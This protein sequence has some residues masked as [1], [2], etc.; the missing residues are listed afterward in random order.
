MKSNECAELN[1]CEDFESS[2]FIYDP[3]DI[4]DSGI[5]YILSDRFENIAP[6]YDS[7]TGPFRLLSAIRYGKKY[8]LKCLKNDIGIP[9]IYEAAFLK[10]FEIG[11]SLDHPNIRSTIGIQEV[12]GIGKAIILEY[13]DGEN[14]EQFLS[15]G[16]I[17]RE[18]ARYIFMQVCF[19]L[20]YMHRKQIIHRDLKTSNIMVTHSGEIVKII[21]FSLS[22]SDAFMIAKNPAGTLSYMAPEVFEEGYR[23]DRKADIWSLGKIARR[24]ADTSGDLNLAGIASRCLKKNPDDRPTDVERIIEI[25]RTREKYHLDYFSLSSAFITWTLTL[26]IIILMIVVLQLLLSRGLITI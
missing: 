22:D 16:N 21:D 14:L 25:L 4:K 11:M 23:T 19:A 20:G 10:E 7:Q 26:L 15:R 12:E 13:I 17:T 18:K 8:V 9:A 2:G 1:D 5:S 3:E 6:L 24:L